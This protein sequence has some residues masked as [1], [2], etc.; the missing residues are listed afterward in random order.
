LIGI[1]RL[2]AGIVLFAAV[3]TRVDALTLRAAGN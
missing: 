2:R 3:A 1:A